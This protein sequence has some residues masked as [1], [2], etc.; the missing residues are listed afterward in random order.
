M[1]E[2][3]PYLTPCYDTNDVVVAVEITNSNHTW[4]RKLVG[5]SKDVDTRRALKENLSIDLLNQIAFTNWENHYDE[6]N[7]HYFT[8]MDNRLGIE[9]FSGWKADSFELEDAEI[10]FDGLKWRLSN[11][12]GQVIVLDDWSK[13]RPFLRWVSNPNQS[14]VG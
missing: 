8:D 2:I 14:F 1:N 9:S 12:E 3:K 13:D 5:F 6:E 4:T 11:D 10:S 7:D